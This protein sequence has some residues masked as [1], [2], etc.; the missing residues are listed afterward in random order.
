MAYLIHCLYRPGGAEERLA[1]RRAHIEHMLEWLPRTAFGAAVLGEAD[2]QPRGM[3]VVLDADELRTARE[4]IDNEPYARQGLF[5]SIAVNP[6]VQMTPPHTREV[7][8]RELG[9]A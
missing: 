8:E 4:F 1:F 7:L 9:R 6:L 2:G 5:E 3:V